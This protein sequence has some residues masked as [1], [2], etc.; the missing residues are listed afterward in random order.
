M[1]LKLYRF[2]SHLF[3]HTKREMANLGLAFNN[4]AKIRQ[5]APDYSCSG[6]L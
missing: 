2:R 5:I 1:Y 6:S 3:M 4:L